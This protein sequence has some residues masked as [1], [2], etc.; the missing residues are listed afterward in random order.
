MAPFAPR[1]DRSLRVIVIELATRAAYDEVITY[2]QLGEAL[3]L[4]PDE[5]GD[6]NRIR[7]AV[8]AARSGLLRHHQRLLV[9]DRGRGYRVARPGE[10]AGVADTYRQQGERRIARALAVINHAP[11]DEMTLAEQRR[12][13]AL[14]IIVRNLN[15]RVSDAEQRLA[16]LEDAVFG[17][18]PKVIPGQAEPGPE[19]EPDASRLASLEDTVFRQR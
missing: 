3:N 14:G 9:A 6:R 19:P 4:D 15:S 1:G 13:R 8:A 11:V 7:Q 10:F 18:P 5:D 2:G 16:E 17:P 12:H